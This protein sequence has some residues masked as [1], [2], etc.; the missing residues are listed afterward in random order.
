MGAIDFKDYDARADAAVAKLPK[1]RASAGSVAHSAQFERPPLTASPTD[2]NA[3]QPLDDVLVYLRR[4]VAYP[5]EHAAIAHALWVVHTH[6]MD[7]WES[8][9]RIAFLSPEPGSGKSRALEA[10]ELLVPN[11][12]NAVN[13]SVAYL[14]FARWAMTRGGRRSSTTR[15]T[16][17]SPSRA[18]TK[19]FA[20][21]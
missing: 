12:V 11:P 2:A 5:T 4:F 10:C 6:L 13:V 14:F 15:W 7:A 21:C 17:C 16:R 9:P 1:A 18:T 19:T 8:T 20:A 3:A